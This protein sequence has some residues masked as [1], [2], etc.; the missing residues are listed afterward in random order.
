MRRLEIV[1]GSRICDRRILCAGDEGVRERDGMDFKR[2]KNGEN[3]KKKTRVGHN[4][5]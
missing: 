2:L 3:D 1:Q 5:I 4:K